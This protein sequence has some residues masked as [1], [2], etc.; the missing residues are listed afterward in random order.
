[1]IIKTDEE[2]KQLEEIGQICGKVLKELVETTK[3]GMTTKEIDELGGRLLEEMGAESAPISEYEF[4]GHT[5]ISVNEEVAHGIPGS[6]VINEG[7]IVNID[8]SAKK[9]GYFADTGLSFIAGTSTDPLKQKVIDVCEA[10]F[11][12]ALKKIKPGTKVSQIGR[13]V[14]KVAR[15]NGLT[16][17]KNLTGHGVGRSL[18]DAPK[19][20]MNYYEPGNSEL[21]K[22]GMVIAVEPFISTK[23]AFVTDG[24]NDWAFETKDGSYVAQKEHTIVVT[25]EGPKL[26][27][28]VED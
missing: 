1:M 13:A 27:T 28:L 17:I 10:S 6:R 4:P 19:H 25:K 16:V 21:L 23:A 3:V 2:M 26:L 9:N 11:E 18:H 12:E 5:C 14:H 24:K 20:I 22:E 7:D 8:V 15:Q